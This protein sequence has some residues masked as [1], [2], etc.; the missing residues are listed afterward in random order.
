VME[1]ATATGS[2]PAG[3]GASATSWNAAMAGPAAL[4]SRRCVGGGSH[5]GQWAA[6]A[7][8]H[9]PRMIVVF[10]LL[11]A[12]AC[13]D[14]HA[15]FQMYNNSITAC[16]VSKALDF[17][18]IPYTIGQCVQK[19]SSALLPDGLR[20]VQVFCDSPNYLSANWNYTEY[21]LSF[22]ALPRI[23]CAGYGTTCGHCVPF[24]LVGT[25]YSAR[26]LCSA[27]AATE[28]PVAAVALG[29]S[30]WLVARLVA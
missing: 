30:L 23:T 21:E 10:V 3:S 27:A 15:L 7:A 29:L 19:T 1:G 24:T 25:A 14:A 5:C 18:F 28:N 11:A 9:L 4:R 22:C 17:H 13:A 20:T 8:A 2:R 12:A 16:N 26:V 6:P